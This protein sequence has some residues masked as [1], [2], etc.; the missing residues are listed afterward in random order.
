MGMM[1]RYQLLSDSKSRE[2]HLPGKD[3]CLTPRRVVEGFED[4]Q[5]KCDL[6]HGGAF[7]GH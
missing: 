6:N 4:H 2:K 3:F 5:L 7:W 1:S